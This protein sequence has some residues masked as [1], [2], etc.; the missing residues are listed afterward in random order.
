MNEQYYYTPNFNNSQNDYMK[1]QIERDAIARRQKSELRK[2]SSFL[3]S[4]II[5]YLVF[6]VIV[7]IV[8]SKV[9]LAK[10]STVYD[11]YQSNAAFSYAVNILFISILSVGLPFGLVAL[12]NR[13]KYKTPIVPTKP[14]KF[15]TAAVWICFGMELCVIAN[16]GTSFLVA[17]FK[18]LGITL[19]QGD[20]AK[21]NSIFECIL[22]IIGI[23]IVPAICEEFA[24]RC[25]ALGLLK[26]YGKAFGVV[27]VSVVFGLLHGNVIQFIF[28][29]LV[30][31]VLAYITIKTE[32]IIPAMCIH[33]LNN[34]MSA[35]SDTV[36][37]AAGKEVNITVGFFAFWLLV[38]IIATIYLAIKRKLTIP[39]DDGNCV[40]T[41][42][43]KVSSFFFPGMILPFIVLIIMTAQTVK[44]G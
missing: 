21:P 34:G 27:S 2:I 3:G 23:A 24:M 15:G 4:A 6:Q 29:F 26:N 1:K 19:T 32:S 42:G 9:T 31:L 33:A 40:L 12:I 17:F 7:S 41:L 37:Y 18:N 38:G 8:M 43:E 5:L 11:L 28:A 13:K 16:A 30:G 10:G 22:D 14:L 35:V 20:V 39:K 44:I 25:C 36:N